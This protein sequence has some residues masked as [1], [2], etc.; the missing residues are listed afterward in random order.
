M[1][2]EQISLI[3][4]ELSIQEIKRIL[5]SRGDDKCLRF[6]DNKRTVS[7]LSYDQVRK[8]IYTRSIG[9]WKHYEPYLKPLI[10]S[11][12]FRH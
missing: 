2:Y 8:P 4:N 6:Y 5:Q 11:L 3:L 1:E 12:G 9:R 7:T 10:E